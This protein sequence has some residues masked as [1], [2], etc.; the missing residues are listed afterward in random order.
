[1][2]QMLVNEEYKM[3]CRVP[4]AILS[5]LSMI[6]SA[7]SSS[8]Y[9]VSNKFGLAIN[10]PVGLCL[11]FS[12]LTVAPSVFLALCAFCFYK[13]SKKAVTMIS[14]SCT[15]IVILLLFGCFTDVI[16]GIYRYGFAIGI[17]ATN[18]LLTITINLPVRFFM[19]IVFLV[20]RASALKGFKKKTAIMV[21]SLSMMII[22]ICFLIVFFIPTFDMSAF[23]FYKEYYEEYGVNVYL[24]SLPA[25]YISDILLGG[26]LLL[27][28][29]S[30]TIPVPS[31]KLEQ[32]PV[33][34]APINAEQELKA[35]VDR[36]KAGIITAEEYAVQRAAI[37]KRL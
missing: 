10:M 4:I 11:A 3:K 2:N 22:G 21:A 30:N 29:L 33:C 19:A 18:T 20:A 24:F 9:F 17:S 36:R 5:I 28:G 16:F 31:K 37:I 6:C 12:A 32:L 23:D 34:V 26:T 1:M 15:L 13:D 27:L 8:I 25:G 35:L 7:L 14:S